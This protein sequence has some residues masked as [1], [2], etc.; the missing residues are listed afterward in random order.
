LLSKIQPH[1]LQHFQYV[2][3]VA[4]TLWIIDRSSF[5]T[6]S[7]GSTEE[8]CWYS[9]AP[10]EPVH[11]ISERGALKIAQSNL[12]IGICHVNCRHVDSFRE[13]CSLHLEKKE[14]GVKHVKDEKAKLER[15]TT[16]PHKLWDRIWQKQHTAKSLNFISQLQAGYLNKNLRSSRKYQNDVTTQI[17][18]AIST[19]QRNTGCTEPASHR[20]NVLISDRVCEAKTIS[21][22]HI[23]HHDQ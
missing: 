20:G 14:N 22:R 9:V 13:I 7:Q 21:I 4:R 1:H 12:E 19:W 18:Q 16:F 15:E 17:F 6:S 5:K 3:D 11:S 2:I 8:S 10:I 23:L